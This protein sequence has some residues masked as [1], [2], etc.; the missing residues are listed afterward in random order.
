MAYQVVSIFGAVLILVAYAAH[1]TKK[2]EADTIVYQLLN[3][4][5]GTCLCITAIES[6]QYGFIMLEGTWAV[7]AAW[8]L[9]RLLKK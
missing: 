8:A 4:A 1:Q 6:R 9:V 2:M 7:V 3:F 5:G